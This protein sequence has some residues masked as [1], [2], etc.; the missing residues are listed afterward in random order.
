MIPRHLHVITT[1]RATSTEKSA[2]EEHGIIL[3]EMPLTRI[4]L[5]SP[6]A[7]QLRPL[8]TQRLPWVFTSRNGVAGCRH[9]LGEMSERATSA[10]PSMVY[11]VGPGT[12]VEAKFWDVP[13]VIP[14]APDAYDAIGLAK[15][16]LHDTQITEVI[17]WCG[18]RRR[19]ELG[20]RLGAA[21]VL[22]HEVIVYDTLPE[23][24]IPVPSVKPDA[25]LFYSPSA[26]EALFEG[27]ALP[28][29]TCPLI[30]IGNTTA[31]ALKLAVAGLKTRKYD[32][33][34]SAVTGQ[35]N[36]H[37]DAGT[38]FGSAGIYTAA[39]ATPDAMMEMAVHLNEVSDD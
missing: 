39:R 11:A 32:P 17:H 28:Q 23:T 9:A 25:V 37:T 8:L 31:D 16:I 15:R 13:V 20:E 35:L 3:H 19:P 24:D 12:A 10:G 4:S 30:A 33:L 1:R 29:W 21:G 6:P 27:G 26:V 2:A 18:V 14:E 7:D 34:E 38:P 5:I 22:V 36:R